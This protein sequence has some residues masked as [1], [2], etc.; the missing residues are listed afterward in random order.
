MNVR[1]LSYYYPIWSTDNLFNLIVAHNTKWGDNYPKLN[2]QRK[3][4]MQE[5]LYEIE[6]QTRYYIKI[7]EIHS[8]EEA[9]D[10]CYTQDELREL[11]GGNIWY[12]NDI[13]LLRHNFIADIN[14]VLGTIKKGKSS[15]VCKNEDLLDVIKTQQL[16]LSQF[17]TGTRRVGNRFG[18]V[19]ASKPKVQTRVMV[20]DWEFFANMFRICMFE[21]TISVPGNMSRIDKRKFMEQF[22]KLVSW[23]ECVKLDERLKDPEFNCWKKKLYDNP[24][25]IETKK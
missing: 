10:V 4:K 13:R 5:R 16:S 6:E 22:K 15:A 18:R 3:Q 25:L 1:S 8:I 23:E 2:K 24:T 17:V 12:G 7:K 19:P 20:Y 9:V 14:E 21:C 11:G